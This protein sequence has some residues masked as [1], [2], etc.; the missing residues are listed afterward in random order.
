MLAI[1]CF[2]WSL[3]L[4]VAAVICAW[5]DGPFMVPAAVAAFDFI[6]GLVVVI[7]GRWLD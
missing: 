6:F 4:G 5:S 7:R 2:S 1:V 3:I